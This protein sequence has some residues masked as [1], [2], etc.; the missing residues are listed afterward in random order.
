MLALSGRCAGLDARR[1]YRLRIE[2][3]SGFANSGRT[4]ADI[5]GRR[6]NGDHVA[7][8][9]K[10][11]VRKMAVVKLTAF[12]ITIAM[13]CSFFIGRL[14]LGRRNFDMGCAGSMQY[15]LRG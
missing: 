14:R 13:V 5:A 1:F 12:R 15:A 10:D 8:E 7:W 11:A 9:D 6:C 3:L 4:E 2:A